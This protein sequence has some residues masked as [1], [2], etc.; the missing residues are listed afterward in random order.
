MHDAESE[1]NTIATI[2]QTDEHVDDKTRNEKGTERAE[3]L[4]ERKGSRAI[5]PGVKSEAAL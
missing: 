2:N 1:Q 5:V 3:G 4:K